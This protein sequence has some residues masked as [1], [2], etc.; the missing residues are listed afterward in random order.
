MRALGPTC[1][2]MF[3][4]KYSSPYWSC[5][6]QGDLC[7][8]DLNENR[9]GEDIQGLDGFLY[10]GIICGIRSDY[11]SIIDLVRND[12]HLSGQGCWSLPSCPFPLQDGPRPPRLAGWNLSPK[13]DRPVDE[14]P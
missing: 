5:I 1:A 11:Q 12:H 14:P 6:G 3:L 2:L 4:K 8:G 7:Y 13:E 9:S 10:L